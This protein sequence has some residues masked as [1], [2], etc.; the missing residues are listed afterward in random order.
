MKKYFIIGGLYFDKVNGNTYHNT[1]IID[2]LGNIYYTGYKYGY[3]NA[4]RYTAQDYIKSV[5]NIN[6]YFIV[7]LG[8]TKHTKSELKN[9][10]F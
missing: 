3:G 4:Y 6:D 7:D 8:T 9:N 2:Y 10:Q 1:K 5:L